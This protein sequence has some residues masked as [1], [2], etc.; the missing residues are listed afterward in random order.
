MGRRDRRYRT[1]FKK[2]TAAKN[3]YDYWSE[4]NY[5][6]S[7]LTIVAQETDVHIVTEGHKPESVSKE[8][9]HEIGMIYQTCN[10]IH[11]VLSYIGQVGI[12]SYRCKRTAG[13][14]GAAEMVERKRLYE[15][16]RHRPIPHPAR[17]GWRGRV[18]WPA[19]TW[20][21]RRSLRLV[22]SPQKPHREEAK[23]DHPVIH[24]W[25]LRCQR[26]RLEG[27]RVTIFSGSN[28]KS[29]THG[30]G[31]WLVALRRQ[32]HPWRTVTWYL[33]ESRDHDLADRWPEGE[34][35]RFL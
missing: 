28:L 32:D 3:T 35:L 17:T 24:G 14:S 19:P 29:S 12:D 9:G 31:W 15:C 8:A 34:N 30:T 11:S 26:R 27:T 13:K 10:E 6:I 1:F 7:L 5:S 25:L 33:Q 20:Y 21:W 2:G 22:E 18:C 4:A 23:C 16:Q